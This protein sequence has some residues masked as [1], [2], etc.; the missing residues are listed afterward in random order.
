MTFLK[1]LILFCSCILIACNGSEQ[2]IKPEFKGITESIYASGTVKSV[3]QY[4]AYATVNGIIKELYVAE[5]DKVKKGT[6]ILYIGN[7]AQVLSMQ[8]SALVAEFSDIAASRGKLSDAR[9][10]IDLAAGR[11]KNDSLLYYRQ[12]YL[13]Q[14]GIGTRVELEQRELAFQNSRNVYAASLV[15]YE[16][17]QR[18]VNLNAKQSRNNLAISSR[19]A[20]DYTLRSEIDGVVYE[21]PRKKGEIVGPQTPLALVGEGNH[22]LLEL[23]V[24]EYDIIQV[25][26]GMLVLITMDSYKG[27]V[28]RAHVTKI[29]PLM[30]ERSKTFV[31]EA[32]FLKAPPRLYPNMTFEA[33]IVTRSK[34]KTL[35]IPRNCMLNDSTVVRSNGDKVFVKTGLKDYQKVEIISGLDSSDELKTP[36]P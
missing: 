8:N 34:S 16:D 23:Q 31:V 20:G 4:E 27:E 9:M 24:D 22:F 13:W 17:L 7:D 12:L 19:L 14:Q 5:G 18:Q 6:P 11:L 1:K 32:Q 28:F 2:K 25:K 33:N 15:A 30:N 21:L 35:V 10:S 29:N 3:N 26:D 36:G